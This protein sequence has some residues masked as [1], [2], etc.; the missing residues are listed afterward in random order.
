MAVSG[1]ETRLPSPQTESADQAPDLQLLWVGSRGGM[2]KALIERAGIPFEGV[3]T[4]QLRLANPLKVMRN[5]GRMAAGV[6]ESQ[7]IVDRFRPDVCFVTGGYVCGPV[8]MACWLRKV[9][10]LIY[11]PDMSPGYAIRMLS[12][13]AARV[14]VSFPEVAHWFGGV[15]P[16]GKAVVTG[17][18]VRT[19]LVE[20]AQD[21]CTARRK[22]ATALRINLDEPD[23]ATLPLVLIWGGSSGARVIN[24][25]TWDALPALLPLAQIVHVVGVRDW[26][27]YAE[28]VTGQMLAEPLRQRYHPV[29]YLHEEM[30]LALAAADLSVARAG[31]STLGE[32]PVAKLPSILAPLHSVN[33]MDNANALAGRGGAVIIEDDDLPAQLAPTVASLLGDPQRRETMQTALAQMAQPDAALA[34][35]NAIIAL[36]KV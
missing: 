32:F 8:V 12:K 30:P 22:L 21:R 10:V 2:E 23:G 19:E 28:W 4:G 24:R 7:V 14:A 29:A 31:A 34:I 11:L 5:L 33:Q 18:P 27:L 26:P 25:S 13:L 20:A 36:T 3:N 16:A 6:R 9:P 15:A 1:V 17:Y 35:A